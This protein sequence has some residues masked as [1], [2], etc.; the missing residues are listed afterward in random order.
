MGMNDGGPWDGGP[1]LAAIF[2]WY[3]LRWRKIKSFNGIF[4]S[5]AANGQKE[6]EKQTLQQMNLKY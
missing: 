5:P 2:S 3:V 6:P 4:I 1:G